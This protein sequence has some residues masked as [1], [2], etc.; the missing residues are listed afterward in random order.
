[1]QGS[2]FLC[3]RI[4]HFYNSCVRYAVEV[5]ETQ[6]LHYL[7]IHFECDANLYFCEMLSTC[8]VT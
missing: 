5:L 7:R 8:M 4:I 6:A 3:P 2:E 1:M